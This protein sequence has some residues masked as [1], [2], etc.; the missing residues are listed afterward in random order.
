[1]EKFY[2]YSDLQILLLS[3]YSDEEIIQVKEFIETNNLF[4]NTRK[5]LSTM[6]LIA[7][8]VYARPELIDNINKLLSY[9]ENIEIENYPPRYKWLSHFTVIWR[10]KLIDYLLYYSP[11]KD[12]EIFDSDINLDNPCINAI[13]DDDIE[14]LQQ[15]ISLN[16]INLNEPISYFYNFKKSL[17]NNATLLQYSALFGSIK[18]FKYLLMNSENTDY[19]SLLKYSIAG[20]NYDIIHITENGIQ[21]PYTKSNN[22]LLYL[23]IQHMNNDLI[24]YIID[25][26]DIKIN[27][28][29]YIQ[30]IYSSNYDAFLAIMEID[31]NKNIN[32]YGEIGSTPLDI[33]AFEGY[34][35]FTKFL[36]SLNVVDA[37]KLNNYG[38][39]ILRSAMK[40]E[41][42]D[43]VKFIIKHNYLSNNYNYK[44]QDYFY[45]YFFCNKNISNLF[46]IK[47]DE[48]DYIYDDTDDFIEENH[49]YIKFMK[50]RNLSKFNNNLKSKIERNKLFKKQ[51]REY[52]KT[53]VIDDQ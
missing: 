17:Y 50:L 27:A 1:M 8:I 48:D 37:F 18:C 23:A 35:N 40:M 33:A 3:M 30:C 46:T 21:N 42:I 12:S 5:S 31:E 45:A 39:S 41:N 13:Y 32:E 51:I 52:Q 19:D 14:Q 38:H 26:Y 53:F 4:E 25:N 16:N 7:S 9:F 11:E 47:S 2:I 36:F 49:C 22:N 24:E 6:K 15:L 28:E 10:Y 20:G 34:L 44:F 43:T 29:C